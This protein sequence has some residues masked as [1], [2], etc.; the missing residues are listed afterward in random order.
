MT[1]DSMASVTSLI[2]SMIPGPELELD[3]EHPIAIVGIAISHPPCSMF[4]F[5]ILTISGQVVR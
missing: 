2:D 3:I 4:S 5:Q 1:K